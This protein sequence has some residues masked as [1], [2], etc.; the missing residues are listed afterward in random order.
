MLLVDDGEIETE[1]TK[2]FGRMNSRRL[3]EV[4]NEQV[5]VCVGI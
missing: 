1:V 2:Y 3:D 4:S 5:T